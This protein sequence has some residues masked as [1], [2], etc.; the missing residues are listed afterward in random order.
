MPLVH[1]RLIFAALSAL[2]ALSAWTM[3]STGGPAW[4]GKVDFSGGGRLTGVVNQVKKADGSTAHVVVKIDEDLSIAVAG[5]HVRHT[6]VAADL[7]EYRD[8][9]AAA[10][11]DAESQFELAHWCKLNTLLPQHRYHLTRT[12]ELD[13]DHQ[14]ARAALGYIRHDNETGWISAEALRRGQGLIHAS[15][16]WVLPEVLAAR[17]QAD[18]AD[19]QSKLWIRKFRRLHAN[20][21]RGESE[22]MAEIAAIDDPMATRAIAEELLR[23]RNSKLNLRPL[24]MSYVRLLGQLRNGATVAALVEMGLNEPDELIREESLRQLTEFG[25]SSAVATYVPLLR[26]NSPAQVDAAARA[27]TFFIDPELAFAYVDAL[28]TEK[29]SQVQVG[30]GGTEA[31]FG[32]SGVSGLTYGSKTYSKTTSVRHPAALELVKSIAPGSDYG[33]DEAAWRRYFAAQRNPYREDLRRD[34]DH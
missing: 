23:S 7:Q 19:K 28:V 15:K 32:N 4:A 22:A 21:A 18:E 33:Y 9:A 1:C 6:V 3:L 8:R 26:S 31:G 5:T 25:A 11:L 12:I 20:A 34:S 17:H 24:R 14:L 16:G 10:G 29:Q 13:P 27:L 30:S 2:V